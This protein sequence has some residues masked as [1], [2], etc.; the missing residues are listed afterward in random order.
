MSILSEKVR[1]GKTF[2]QERKEKLV[3]PIKQTNPKY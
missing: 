1:D 3:M 2:G